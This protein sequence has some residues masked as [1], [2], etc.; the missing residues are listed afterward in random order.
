MALRGID[1]VSATIFLAEIGDLSRF[2][3]PRE[4][5]AYL[6][7]VP[8]ERRPATGSSAAASPRPA[9]VGRGAFWSSAPGAIAIPR[10]SGRRSLRRL[11]PP[12]RRSGD[13]LEG[14]GAPVRA[15]PGA[16]PA[17]QTAD[18]RGDRDRARAVGLHLGRQSRRRRARN[19]GYL[20]IDRATRS[21]T[22][23]RDPDKYRATAGAKPRQGNSRFRY[24]A[25]HSIDARA[26]TEDSPGRILGTA[27]QTRESELD[28]R[29]LQA[30]SPP[31]H[32]HPSQTLQ[33]NRM[34]PIPRAQSLDQ[35][36]QSDIRDSRAP[37]PDVGSLIRA[38]ACPIFDFNNSVF[39]RYHRD[40]WVASQIPRELGV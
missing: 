8:S 31:L 1:L 34:E 33:R 5:M 30:S 16:D 22:A 2:A 25:D 35:G 4:L 39:E 23:G 32:D 14:A 10:G 37:V 24:V 26:K 19:A 11:R 38:T 20:S 6:G 21:Q 17:R 13:R 27:V 12:A 9:T 3:T 7:L 40:R 36:H 15:L 28:H 29:R 18:P